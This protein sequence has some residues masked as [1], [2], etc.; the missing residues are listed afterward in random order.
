MDGNKKKFEIQIGE[1]KK[2]VGELLL[3]HD[4]ALV[5]PGQAWSI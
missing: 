4:P 3:G 1:R 5:I 2:V